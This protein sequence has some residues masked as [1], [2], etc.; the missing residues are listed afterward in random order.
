[1]AVLNTTSP[2]DRPG[3]GF[4]LE[5]GAV[6]EDEDCG[7]G[8]GNLTLATEGLPKSRLRFTEIR[9]QKRG[10]TVWDRSG[11]RDS[12]SANCAAGA[13]TP[14]VIALHEQAIAHSFQSG[15]V[16]AEAG[17]DPFPNGKGSDPRRRMGSELRWKGIRPQESTR[18]TAAGPARGSCLGPGPAAGA[19]APRVNAVPDGASFFW[20]WCDSTMSQSQPASALRRALHQFV[21]YRHAQ[22]EVRGPYQR[23][24]RRRGVQR[25][26]L[27]AGDTGGTRQPGPRSAHSAS[28][29]RSPP[30]G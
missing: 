17:S 18:L 28:S 13:L 23:D 24:L 4:A 30:A 14:A 12:A 20:V 22:A 7:L 29:G 21:Q 15:R 10:R 25:L 16:W 3:A 5:Y 6:F 8:H 9:L 19:A 27:C 2:T 26:A 1:M 11:F